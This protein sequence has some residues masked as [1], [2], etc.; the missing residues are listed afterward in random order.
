MVVGR[1][2]LTEIN[3]WNGAEAARVGQHEHA[4]PGHRRHAR[5]ETHIVVVVVVVAAVV[6]RIV[7]RGHGKRGKRH[8]QGRTLKRNKPGS[9]PKDGK[10]E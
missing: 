8:Q 5:D 4:D 9:F 1:E 7:H 6:V 2:Q 10:L 3:V